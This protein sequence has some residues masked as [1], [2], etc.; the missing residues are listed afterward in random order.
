MNGGFHGEFHDEFHGEFHGECVLMLDAD[1]STEE[2]KRKLKGDLDNMDSDQGFDSNV[3]SVA[4]RRETT[5][6]WLDVP[7]N[8]KVSSSYSTLIGESGCREYAKSYMQKVFSVKG[9]SGFFSREKGSFAALVG[10]QEDK[11]VRAEP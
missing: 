5:N 6:Y 10:R 9:V 4:K 7:A 11:F 1:K 2:S 3:P 8:E